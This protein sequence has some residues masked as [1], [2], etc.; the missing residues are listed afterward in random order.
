MMIAINIL[1]AGSLSISNSRINRRVSSGWKSKAL[2]SASLVGP[3]CRTSSRC[4]NKCG[5]SCKKDESYMY[6]FRWAP[7]DENDF[8]LP[9]RADG[10]RII[11]LP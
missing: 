3:M 6:K 10:P 2:F 9:Q 8:W 7:I 1:H 4:S 5:S 11:V